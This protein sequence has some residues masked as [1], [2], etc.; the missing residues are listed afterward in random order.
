VLASGNYS[1]AGSATP[2]PDRT[3]FGNGSKTISAWFE[4]SCFT[5]Q[6]LKDANAQGIYLYGNSGRNILSAPGL[7]DWD[8]LTMK[9]FSVK[10]RLKFELRFEFY[11]LFNTPNYAHP[12]ARI[13]SSG[14]GIINNTNGPAREIQF[15]AKMNF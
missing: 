8:F 12:G 9:R 7:Q 11:N 14:F 10:E 3:C 4:T 13:D 15:G 5:T 2:R 1:N 6:Y